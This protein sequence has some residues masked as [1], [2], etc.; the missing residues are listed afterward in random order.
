VSWIKLDDQFPDHPKVLAA[1]PAAAWLYVCG[2]AYAS[3]Y[4]TDG[5]IP[6]VQV[7]RLADVRQAPGLARRLVD[8]GLWEVVDAGYQIHD[9]LEYQDP[10]SKVQAKREEA[11]ERMRK[12]RGGSQN[13][14][15]SQDVRANKERS[16]QKVSELAAAPQPL[17]TNVL[18]S[19]S[20]PPTPK[21][22]NG[23]AAAAAVDDFSPTY[24]TTL[25]D[26]WPFAIQGLTKLSP[27]ITEGMAQDI[28][29]DVERDVGAL[30]VKQLRAGLQASVMALERAMN[31]TKPITAIRP[32]ATKVITE[33]L[34]EVA[35]VRQ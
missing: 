17:S 27:E 14:N 3:R 31:G 23:A 5:F 26:K 15:G 30:S 20:I 34:R 35:N 8:A 25:G 10:S 11:R 1:G 7:P 33:R 2:L 6:A 22:A 9:Y 13:A 4:L 21:T 18:N 32:F 28:L 24:P 19:S 12:F 16:S 29:F